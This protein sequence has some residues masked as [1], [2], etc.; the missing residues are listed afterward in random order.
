MKNISILGSTGS[1]G[2]QT[3]EVI[4]NH[5]DEFKVLALSCG[6][7]I[8][9]FRV[10]LK[11]F[12]PKFAVCANEQDA[13]ALSKEF[14][15]ID[16]SYG[17]EGLCQL[18]SLNEADMV[19][20]SLLGMMGLRPTF[21]A[22]SAKKDIAFANKETLVAGG[23]FLT[24][25]VK[26]Q[27]IK[28]LPVDSE[29]SAIFQSL[30]GYHGSGINKILL[31]ASGGP[32]RGYTKEQLL[33]VTKEQALK[34]PNWNMGAK[35]TI[36]SATMMNKGLEIIEASLL[37]DIKPSKIEVYV[38]P[39]SVLHSAVEFCDGAIIGQMGVPDMKVPIAYALSWPTRLSNIAKSVNLFE[40]GSLH[41]EKPDPEVF[42]CL[43]LA[44]KAIEAGH[45]YQ[46]V[47]NAAN[48]EAVQAFLK[49]QISFTQIADVIEDTMNSSKAININSVDDIFELE[50][51]SRRL[52][53]DCINNRG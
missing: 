22:V 25:A 15:D 7:N 50:K 26:A 18:A 46:I 49:D 17:I 40:L 39:E 38:H 21:A 19:V 32:F 2:T 41:F 53:L 33:T 44:Y 10:Q 23:R 30:Q 47:M 43:G 3:L 14:S 6:H 28:L 13:V 11:E 52:A 27:G 35:I 45:S 36:D 4:K 5:S 51:Q 29:H 1:I 37:F 12:K 9:L 48:E 16:F 31:T 20:N 42:R 8:D 34:H 24:D